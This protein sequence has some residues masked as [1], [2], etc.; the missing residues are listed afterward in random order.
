[1]K[2]VVSF[3]FAVILFFPLAADAATV[4]ALVDRNQV[5]SGE[6]IDFRISIEGK[7]GEPDLSAITDFKVISRGKSSR[8]QMIN[9]RITREIEYNYLLLPLREGDLH[10]PRL[11]VRVGGKTLY[12]GEIFVK[13]LKQSP[14]E[15]ENR[16]VYAI[17]DLSEKNPYVDQQIIYTFKLYTSVQIVNAQFERPDFEGFS[18]EELEER[19]SF[20]TTI[21]GREYIVTELTFILVPLAAGEKT[22][23]SATLEFGL[24]QRTRRRRSSGIDSFFGDSFFSRQEVKTRILKTDPIPVEVRPLPPYEGPGRF[25]GLV[26]QFEIA[27]EIDNIDL[28]AGDSTTLSIIV[29]GRGNIMDARVP[30]IPVPDSFKTYADN[31]EEAVDIGRTGYSGKKIFR[32]ALVPV[33]EGRFLI[34]PIQLTYFDV[35][36]GRYVTQTTPSFQLNVAPSEAAV[37]DPAVF[38]SPKVSLSTIKKKVEFTGRDIF[39]IKEELDAIE[40]EEK[41]SLFRYLLLILSPFLLTMGIKLGINWTRKNTDAAS[42]M[43]ERAKKA[44]K[45]AGGN[46]TEDQFISSLYRAVVSAI[47]AKAGMR[48]ESL[49]WSEARS[50]L[51]SKGLAEADAADAAKLLETIE[52]AGYSGVKLDRTGRSDL[53]NR[54][55]KLVGRLSG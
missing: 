8:M 34:D 17:V 55:K 42:L 49:T 53:L 29:K 30:E 12:T 25:S 5:V 1:M 37:N 54:T 46:L 35:G 4:K 15:K 36:K 11:P 43:M 10:I 23:D 39:P 6:S 27:S 14:S 40:H 9:G 19:N 33:K 52:T 3:I 47:L 16:D 45:E 26:G 50:L 13:V 18:V 2:S 28:K 32:I 41:M 20:R 44:L 24:V 22:I 48:G 21:N 38:G 51:L 7:A 31:P